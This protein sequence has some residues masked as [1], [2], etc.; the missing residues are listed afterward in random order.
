MSTPEIQ[1]LYK[2]LKP[3]AKRETKP[4]YTHWQLKLSDVTITA[5]TSGKVV[6]QGS[7]LSWLDGGNSSASSDSSSGSGLSQT[8]PQAGS[9]EVGNGDYLGPFVVASAIVPDAQTAARLK[10]LRITDSKAMTDDVIRRVAPEL[11]E[12]LPN[13]VQILDNT[14]Y[15]RIYDK[16]TMNLN[17]IKA[18]MHNQAYL[19][20]QKKGF[21]LPELMVVDQFCQP[22]TYYGYLKD[23]PDVIR[24]L[25]FETKAESR[26]PAVAAA[27]VLARAA[28]LDVMDQ[29]AEKY[30]MPIAKGGGAQATACARKLV[31][32]HGEDVLVHVAK[33]HFTNTAKV[34]RH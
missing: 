13:S 6:Y 1:A 3:R 29:L 33:L 16:E 24:T 26:Y 2:R 8:F 5:Y 23:V 20:L 21:E 4:N 22:K 10:E 19:N 17:V 32:K 31:E 25:H 30:G 27:S 14:R 11:R 12:L 7:D 34:V 9:D 28:F 18:R 15:N